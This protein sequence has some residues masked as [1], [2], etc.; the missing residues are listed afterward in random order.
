MLGV[1]FLT[2]R[3][4]LI[5]FP[6]GDHMQGIQTPDFAR[7]DAANGYAWQTEEAAMVNALIGAAWHHEMDQRSGIM[8]RVSNLLRKVGIGSRRSTW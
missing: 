2:V 3:T 7:R 5:P 8:S 6:G 4:H 1:L